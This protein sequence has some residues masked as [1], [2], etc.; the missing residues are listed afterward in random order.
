MS[1]NTFPLSATLKILVLSS[2]T[3]EFVTK[4][5]ILTVLARTNHLV[6]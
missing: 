5:N 6:W 2:Q 4:E 1:P 3:L